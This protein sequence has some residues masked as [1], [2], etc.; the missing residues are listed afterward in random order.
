MRS[1][2]LVGFVF[3]LVVV[4]GSTAALRVDATAC[5][6][7]FQARNANLDCALTVP[8]GTLTL[9]GSPAI[10]ADVRGGE[11]AA[12]S[13]DSLGRPVAADV[14]GARTSYTYGDDGRLAAASG[15]AVSSRTRMTGSAGSWQQAT[16]GSRTAISG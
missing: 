8:G 5:S 4:P 9:A 10:T 12:F 13:Y 11:R 2:L 15:Q 1:L 7:D 6:V 14:G 3:V 16:R